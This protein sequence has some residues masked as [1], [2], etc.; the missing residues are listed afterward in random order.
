MDVSEPVMM[1]VPP[2]DIKGRA[3][4]AVKTR[5]LTLVPKTRSKWSSVIEP[6]GTISPMPGVGEDD[7]DMP[8]FLAD[9]PVNP[10]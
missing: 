4:C 8:L 9:L 7:V 5:P 10:V 3:F 1:I 2:W 6:N